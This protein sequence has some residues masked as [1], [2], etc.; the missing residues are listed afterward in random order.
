M[1]RI[2]FLGRSLGE[3]V[4]PPLDI[5]LFRSKGVIFRRGLSGDFLQ[6]VNQCIDLS[7]SV[8]DVQ[9]DAGQP[10]QR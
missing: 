5:G 3:I 8:L 1:L 7:D 2:N 10:R 9:A 6:Y 4:H